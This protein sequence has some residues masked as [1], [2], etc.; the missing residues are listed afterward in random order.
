MPTYVES[1]EAIENNVQVKAETTVEG[2]PDIF[3]SEFI[4]NIIESDELISVSVNDNINGKLN[5][6]VN[7]RYTI[8]PTNN[9]SLQ[10]LDN[11]VVTC[12]VPEGI[13]YIGVEESEQYETQGITYTYENG[14]IT[15]N[16]KEFNTPTLTWKGKT[17]DFTEGFE[18]TITIKAE[19]QYNG[20]TY[21]SEEFNKSIIKEGFSV[22]QKVDKSSEYISSRRR[23]NI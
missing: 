23:S 22:A 6:G 4:S 3:K 17:L 11:V 20:K 5:V 1:T 8:K 15:W 9:T 16:I 2:Y 19:A 14:V 21:S 7:V 12:K 10:K 18:K 13:E